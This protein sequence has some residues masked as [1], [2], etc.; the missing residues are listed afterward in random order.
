MT[1][2]GPE[3]H[4]R[5]RDWDRAGS[6]AED[7]ARRIA[8]D[9]Q[10]FG[11]RVAE[12]ATEFARNVRREWEHGPG[13]DTTPIS[14]DVRGM[15]KEVRGLVADVIDGV[16]DLIGRVF[17]PEGEEAGRWAKVV[18]NHE[19]TCAGCGRAIGAGEECHLLRRRDTR[20]FRCAQCGPLQSSEPPP[21]PPSA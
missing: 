20:A 14:K 2:C 16:D 13:F 17:H 10:R 18:T 6:A 19:V 11:E 15:L 12:H 3:H 9:A 8:R 7:F 21:P 4:Y 5:R 1:H